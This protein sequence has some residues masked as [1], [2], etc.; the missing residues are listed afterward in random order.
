M[1]HCVLSNNQPTL[2]ITSI[3]EGL[4]YLH[5]CK[6]TTVAGYEGSLGIVHGDVRPENVVV[7]EV[8]GEY[9]YL[10]SE[11]GMAHVME[12][13]TGVVMSN[14]ALSQRYIAPE[15]CEEN[16]FLKP[17][18][19]VFGFAMTAYEVRMAFILAMMPTNIPFRLI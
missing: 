10:L 18:A 12:D 13:V 17:S 14:M 3:A 15:L 8:D 7:D 6:L 5:S 19:D 9:R 1:Y 11:F 16:A 4:A 2:Q